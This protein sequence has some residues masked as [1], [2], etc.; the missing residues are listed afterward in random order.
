MQ[1][2]ID[3]TNEQKKALLAQYAS[4]EEYTSRVVVNRANR[5]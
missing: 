2:N 5:L 3:L 4:I 1:I